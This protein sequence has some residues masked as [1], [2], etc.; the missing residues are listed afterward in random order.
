[1]KRFKKVI[2]L[3]LAGS[4]AITVTS[5]GSSDNSSTSSSESTDKGTESEAATETSSSFNETGYPIYVGEEPVTLTVL[6]TRWGSMGDTFTNNQWL[7]DLEEKTN[8]KIEW[9][10]QSLNDW[11]EQKGIL[12]ASGELPD[13]IIGQQTF[14]DADILNSQEMFLPLDDLIENYMPNY[15]AALEE[16]PTLKKAATSLDGNM[17]SFAKNIPL[18]PKVS[19]QPVINK[20]WL[21]RLGLEEPT[22]LD[23]LYTVLKA[24]K[25]QDANGNGDP[26][27]EIPIA[28]FTID[29]L[30]PF[31]VTDVY[32]SML[33]VED[34]NVVFTPSDERYKE[35]LTWL[36]KLYE[37]GILDQEMFTQDETMLLGKNQDP[38]ISRVGFTYQWSHD[39]VFGQWSDEYEIIEPI[40]GPDGNKYASG[41]PD[42]VYSITRNEALITAN[43]ENPE[44]AARW[45]D[46]FYTGEASI[47][48]FWGA[49][50]TVI[51]K[52][53]DGTY[54]LNDPPEGVSA[55][56]WYWDQS[57][58]D[59]GPKYV[60]S[61]FEQNIVLSKESGDGLKVETSKLAEDFITTPYPTVIHTVEENDE[62]T[63]INADISSFVASKRAEWITTG[64]IEEG[65]DT[66]IEQ[67]NQMG[68]ER[69]LE[70][71]TDAYS[72]Y[73]E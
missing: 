27:D 20:A 59:F 25:E 42:G 24:F 5:C 57:L 64:G 41:D 3:L 40:A 10:V 18:R 43:C 45:L 15:K 33:M 30:Q 65:W 32:N 61:E 55:D 71:K 1:M 17:Y 47:Q 2:S 63:V 13:I 19:G 68:L 44:I 48:N 66:Y 31:G 70:I 37:E 69:F 23:E 6:T 9:Q 60:S 34:G 49:I 29:L 28:G 52:H 21:D 73:N 26:N 53:D 51:T 16:M 7:K 22:T 38:D 50:D 62:L 11:G 67:L 36:H 72:R 56:A 8:V 14:N 4:M 58:R 46:E 35:A 39:A 12:L 54:T